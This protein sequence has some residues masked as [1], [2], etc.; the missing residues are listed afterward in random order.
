MAIFIEFNNFYSLN[1]FNKRDLPLFFA[2]IGKI[3]DFFFLKNK[4]K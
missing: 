1:Q 3:E 2:E 4:I